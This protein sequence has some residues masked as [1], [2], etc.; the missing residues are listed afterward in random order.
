MTLSPSENLLS[1]H[2]SVDRMDE[3]LHY[4]RLDRNERVSPFAADVFLGV[5]VESFR[6]LAE[7]TA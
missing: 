3:R 2:R 1:I 7:F 5:N 6:P 4:V